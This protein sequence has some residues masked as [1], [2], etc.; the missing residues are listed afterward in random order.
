MYLTQK[1]AL[2]LTR[3]GKAGN[4]SFVWPAGVNHDLTQPQWVAIDRYDLHRVDHY[5][6][7]LQDLRDWA[8]GKTIN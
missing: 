7:T 6:P 2:S 3:M 5:P 8:T 4:K 1:V